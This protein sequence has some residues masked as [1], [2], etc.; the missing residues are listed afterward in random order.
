MTQKEVLQRIMEIAGAEMNAFDFK[1]EVKEQR[2]LRK[3]KSSFYFY[4]FLIYNRTNIKAG[5]KGFQIEPY[6][7]INIPEIEDYH[8]K[9]TTNDELKKEWDSTTIGNSMANLLANPD[10]I[11]K[12]RNQSL[13]LYI[14][15]EGH[16]KPAAN[17]LLKHFKKTALPYFLTNNTVK[18][19]DE[20]LNSHPMEYCVHM[21]NDLYRFI[22]GLI[23]AKLNKNS[24]FEK[25]LRIY[26]GLATERSMPDYCKEEMHRLK[27]ILPVM[28]NKKSH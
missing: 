10:G 2:F 24:G 14:F 21:N 15:E 7:T 23:A 28:G 20:L 11:N 18:R 22:K 4:T 9:I 12:K 26:D 1:A 6:A 27:S 17:E 19:V 3:D 13:A 8:K 25:L 5:T 16:I